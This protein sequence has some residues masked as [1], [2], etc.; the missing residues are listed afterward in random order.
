MFQREHNTQK[1][2][3]LKP[4]L[5]GAYAGVENEH[6][7]RENMA[8]LAGCPPRIGASHEAFEESGET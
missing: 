7:P 3:A 2:S 8:V 1:L 4:S 6:G 5:G